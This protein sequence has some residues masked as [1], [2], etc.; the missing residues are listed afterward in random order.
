MLK[1]AVGL[2]DEEAIDEAIE[3]I[4]HLEQLGN[5]FGVSVSVRLN[6]TFAA[7]GSELYYQF[8]QDHYRPPSLRDVSKVIE[9]CHELGVRIPIFLGLND[10]GLT[11]AASSFGNGDETDPGYR[12]ALAAYNAHQ[13]LDRLQRDLQKGSCCAVR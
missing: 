4:V 8:D 2:T 12:A 11:Y 1:P 9:G 10:E 7:V 3:T 6:P 13:D 5:H